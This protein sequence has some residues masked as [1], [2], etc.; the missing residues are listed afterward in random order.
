SDYFDRGGLCLI[1]WADRVADR[2]PPDAWT[3]T[4]SPEA[5]KRRFSLT[6][7]EPARFTTLYR[8][9]GG[10]PPLDPSPQAI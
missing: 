8:S 9:L 2:L 7:P 5:P 4:I 6:L 3:I 1:E 10:S